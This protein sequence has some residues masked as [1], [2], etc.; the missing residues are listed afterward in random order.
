MV[1]MAANYLDDETVLRKLPFITP[2][3]IDSIIARRTAMEQSMFRLK[4][5]MEGEEP[6]EEPEEEEEV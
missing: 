4:S 1:M 2:D 5:M 6:E 3:E